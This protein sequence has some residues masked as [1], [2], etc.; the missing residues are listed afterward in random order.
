MYLRAKQLIKE[1]IFI[2][3]IAAAK[4]AK[5]D[6]TAAEGLLS[7][8]CSCYAGRLVAQVRPPSTFALRRAGR[9]HSDFNQLTG[10]AE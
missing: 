3:L 5:F 9:V 2:S 4:L 8:I 7:H 6:C 10:R 1:Y